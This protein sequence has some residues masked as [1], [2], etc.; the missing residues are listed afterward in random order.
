VTQ[1]ARTLAGEHSE[2]GHGPAGLDQQDREPAGPAVP[3]EREN[4]A[5]PRPPA[6]PAAGRRPGAGTSGGGPP[7]K[8]R[9][10]PPPRAGTAPPSWGAVLATTVRLWWQ[11]RGPGGRRL[12]A[13]A[14]TVTVAV[15]LLAG[16]AIAVALASGSGSGPGAA[17]APGPGAT[18]DQARQL[19]ASRAAAAARLAAA[20]WV[21]QQVAPDAIVGCDPQMCTALE[22]AGLPASR[23]LYLGV[24]TAGPLGSDVLVSTAAV[25]QKYGA[26]L[27]SVAA[28]DV[29]ASFGTGRAESA[30]RVVAPDGAAAYQASLRATQSAAASAGRRLLR[31]PR[32]HP[33]AAAR[34][35]L[36]AGQADSRVLA[37]LAALAAGHPLRVIDFPAAP[38]GASTGLPLRTADIAP[39][40]FGTARQPDNLRVL[41]RVLLAEPARYRPASVARLR[42]PGG[43]AM[44]RITFLFP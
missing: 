4:A 41:A 36:A 18:R 25:R 2:A 13:A 10:G 26:R 29:L 14:V 32:L 34:Q 44:L 28:P 20:A 42:Q 15:L 31:S 19:A 33:S 16:A 38:A 40:G 8:R 3:Q 24:G 1:E 6:G 5:Q 39:A 17:P 43:Q 27:A 22:Q 9:G 21:A 7:G 11:R 12:I 37:D 35:V 30:V 23:L